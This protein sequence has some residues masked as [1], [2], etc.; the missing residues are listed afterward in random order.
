V[1]SEKTVGRLSLYRRVLFGL[2]AEDRT[3]IFS[4][5]LAELVG[6]TAAQVRRD[7]MALGYSGSPTHGYD[8]PH[9]I[10][11]IG[12]FLDAPLGQPTALV[13]IGHLGSAILAYFSGRRPKLWIEAAFDND[14]SRVNRLVHGCRAYPLQDLARIVQER[15]IHIGIVTVPPDQAQR[16]ADQLCEA[17]VYGLL[18]FAA[19]RLAVPKGVHV[20]DVDIIASFEK[21]A[22]F[23]RQRATAEH[24]LG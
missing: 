15:G 17:G 21:V 4:R 20:E 16:V 18:N 3:H 6:G 14:P 22:Y 1:I 8:I 19:V 23:A 12:R 9:F 24:G 5:E 11:S 10:E 7:V 13:G 2:L